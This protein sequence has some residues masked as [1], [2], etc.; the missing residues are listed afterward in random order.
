MLIGTVLLQVGITVTMWHLPCDQSLLLLQRP[1]KEV[2]QMPIFI[3]HGKEDYLVPL[4]L[5]NKTSEGLKK[6]GK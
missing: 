3:G 1:S 2:Q 6:A 5:A 4:D